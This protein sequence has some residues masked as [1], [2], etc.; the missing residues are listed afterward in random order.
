[1]RIMDKPGEPAAI[2]ERHAQQPED[3]KK[4]YHW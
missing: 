4:K 2:M 1:M 3:E